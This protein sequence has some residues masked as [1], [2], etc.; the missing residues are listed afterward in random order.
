[1]CVVVCV[2]KRNKFFLYFY[3]IYVILEYI[4]KNGISVYFII[5]Y[6]ILELNE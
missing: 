2:L 3:I 5:I 4:H 6:I 1:M